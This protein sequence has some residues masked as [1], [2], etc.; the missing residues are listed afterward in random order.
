MWNTFHY[1]KN[2]RFLSVCL[3]ILSLKRRR[4]ESFDSAVIVTVILVENPF[5]SLK[6]WCVIQEIKGMSHISNSL[7]SFKKQFSI[8]KILI[9]VVSC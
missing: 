6:V 9:V 8:P 7:M 4:A 2:Y 5:G 3:L 1:I